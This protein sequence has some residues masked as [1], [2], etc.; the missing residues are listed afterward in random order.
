MV[1][2][3][4]WGTVVFFS[5]FYLVCLFY[6]KGKKHCSPLHRQPPRTRL[7]SA[8][9]R[10]ATKTPSPLF[11][12]TSTSPTCVSRGW[13]YDCV[14]RFQDP[15]SLSILYHP[16]ADAVFHAAPRIEVLA[17]CHWK[18]RN[19]AVFSNSSLMLTLTHLREQLLTHLV[20]FT[21]PYTEAEMGIPFTWRVLFYSH[22]QCVL[23]PDISNLNKV[24]IEVLSTL[25]LFSL[26]FSEKLQG[27]P[28]YKMQIGRHFRL[29]KLKNL[30]TCRIKGILIPFSKESLHSSYAWVLQHYEAEL[31]VFPKR[32]FSS[33][34][35]LQ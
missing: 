23:A 24:F 21:T 27:A 35:C 4:H 6:V 19:Q 1:S 5:G 20:Q 22:H 26:I 14:S 12:R 16:Q 2:T 9:S 11:A 15:S 10:K 31:P 8:S 13:L 7:R 28:L 3:A 18:Q 33:F 17:F 29:S 30:K 25:L 34:S 32:C